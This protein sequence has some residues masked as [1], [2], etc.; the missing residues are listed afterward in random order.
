VL[1]GLYLGL[2]A[3]RDGVLAVTILEAAMA[4]MITGAV[5]AAERDLAPSLAS[6]MVGLGVPLSLLTV[7]AW[8]WLLGRLGI[9]TG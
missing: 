2:G 9:G 7:P 5:L 6:N 4:P 1:L 8:A 3:Q